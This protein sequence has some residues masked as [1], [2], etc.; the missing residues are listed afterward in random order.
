MKTVIAVS[1]QDTPWPRTPPSPI[2]AGSAGRRVGVVFRAPRFGP[3]RLRR[4]GEDE[5]LDLREAKGAQSKKHLK[6]N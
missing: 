4:A 1:G 6:I 2:N 3:L 5:R